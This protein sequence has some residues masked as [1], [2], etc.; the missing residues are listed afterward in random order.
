MRQEIDGF[1]G[2]ADE[3]IRGER[4]ADCQNTTAKIQN[5]TK[6]PHYPYKLMDAKQFLVLKNP[7]KFIKIEFS[8]F[9]YQYA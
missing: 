7:T 6:V 1:A 4:M 3:T 8:R 9:I 2:M 5:A